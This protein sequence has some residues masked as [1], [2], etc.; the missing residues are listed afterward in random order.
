MTRHK[1]TA[2]GELEKTEQ[3]LSFLHLT[4]T[5]D[6]KYVPAKYL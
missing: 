2:P 5:L 3:E 1:L 6:L 4:L